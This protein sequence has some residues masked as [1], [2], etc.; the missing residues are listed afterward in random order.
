MESNFKIDW[1]TLDI[2]KK[3]IHVSLG[4]QVGIKRDPVYDEKNVLVDTHPKNVIDFG[5]Q[6]SSI[7]KIE[8]KIL[9]DENA[10]IKELLAKKKRYNMLNCMKRFNRS[11][12]LSFLKHQ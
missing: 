12:L 5:G 3:D 1:R 11:L 7:L 10:F 2:S 8:N 6:E 9:Q 4:I